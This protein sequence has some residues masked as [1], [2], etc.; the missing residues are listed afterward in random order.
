MVTVVRVWSAAPFAISSKCAIISVSCVISAARSPNSPTARE[1]MMFCATPP[2][3]TI[4]CTRA[5]EG[6]CWRQPS[7]ATKSAM[8]AV[9]ALRPFSGETAAC[10][11]KPSKMTRRTVIP[12][13]RSLTAQWASE[14]GCEYSVATVSRNTPASMRSSFPPP[15]SSA[16]VPMSSMPTCRSFACAAAR[17]NPPT[18]VI[19]M[20]LW[21]QPCPTSG[22]ASYSAMNATDG[23]G[24]PTRAR[25]AVSSPPSGRS[26]RWPC[27]ARSVV[28]R[29]TAR[30]SW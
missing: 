7:S 1:G 30:R 2:S 9:S 18:L 29:S 25:N 13:S 8:S 12:R 19:A 21:P 23:P 28:I 16:G 15:L 14:P 26:A 17:R 24:G 5:V 3:R 6:R 4:P 27:L 20:R 11:A 10:D 22:S